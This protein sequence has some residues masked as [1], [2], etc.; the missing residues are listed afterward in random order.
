MIII[1]NCFVNQTENNDCGLA[2]LTMVLKYF[3][4]DTS[5]KKLKNSIS[6]KDEMISVYD[7]IKI[8]KK[9]GILATGY[10]NVN[11]SDLKFPCIIHVIKN[12]KQHFITLL[13]KKKNK[14]LQADPSLIGMSYISY[15]DLKNKYT[16]VAIFFEKNNDIKSSFFKNKVLI[17][18][19]LLLFS[20]ITLLNI[21]CSFFIPIL[22]NLRVN[23]KNLSLILTISLLFFTF[24]IIKDLMNYLKDKYLVRLNLLVD[25]FVT[26]PTINKIINLPHKF[27]HYNSSGKLIT[28]INDLSY[29]KEGIY[30]F[31]NVIIINLM[32]IIIILTILLFK[33]IFVFLLSVIFILVIY[34]LN[35]KFIKNNL[36][37]IYEI[38]CLNE[39]MY[40]KLSSTFKAILMIKNLSK[41]N[42][43]IKDINNTHEDIMKMNCNFMK[44]QERFNLLL[45]FIITTMSFLV[46]LILLSQNVRITDILIL[47]SLFQTIVDSSNQVSKQIPLYQEFKVAY[48]R[49]NDVYQKKELE[50]TNKYIDIN[51]ITIKNLNF[52]YENNEVLKDVN[53]NINK[54]D[55]IFINGI[56]GSGKSTLFKIIT[57]QID[58]DSNSIFINKTNLNDIKEEIIRNSIM[59]V[60]QKL[61]LI[62]ASIKENIFMGDTFDFK[63][64]KTALVDEMLKTNKIDYDYKIDSTNSN[65]SGGQISKIIIAQALNSKRDFI[66]FD[67][68]TSNL[69]IKTERR[70]FDNIKRKYKDKTIIV[71]THRKSNINYFNKVFLFNDGKIIKLK[72][73]EIL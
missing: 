45:S 58:F 1:S 55:W 34:I 61:N 32:F 20:F 22:V 73:G 26:M 66:I 71:I 65:L 12:G 28:K 57:K 50:K 47:F 30:V 54:G 3:N 15:E 70:I 7:I 48:L 25:K 59:Y 36:N 46:I 37:K 23:N 13:D 42:Y 39:I 51:K 16:G 5:L 44:K 41:E 14:F 18:K 8:S 40:D 35:K 72:K 43:F 17:L 6:Y 29:I 4:I 10:K 38:Q 31:L 64:V 69:D 49:I 67:E 27:Y 52:S 24:Q 53:L 11:I 21:L 33:N 19:S 63:P 2:C 56:T 9:Y 60:D 62:N 68:T